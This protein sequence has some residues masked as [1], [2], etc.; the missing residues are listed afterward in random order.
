MAKSAQAVAGSINWLPLPPGPG[1]VGHQILVERYGCPVARSRRGEQARN[2]AATG[3][4]S[5]AEV[6]F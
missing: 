2:A 5:A 1:V 4:F 3:R 6:K